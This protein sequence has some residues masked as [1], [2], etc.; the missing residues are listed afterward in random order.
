MSY[1][2]GRTIPR[3]SPPAN[4]GAAAQLPTEEPITSSSDDQY[5][6]QMKQA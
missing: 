4:T 3:G 2:E 1:K 5:T 6:L